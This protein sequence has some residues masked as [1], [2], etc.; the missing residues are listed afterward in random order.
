MTYDNY[1]AGGSPAYSNTMARPQA[2]APA[3]P[4]MSMAEWQ[5]Y[6]ASLTPQQLQEL[7]AQAINWGK[8]DG[9]DSGGGSWVKRGKRKSGESGNDPTGG[10]AISWGTSDGSGSGN[11]IGK[12]F[13]MFGGG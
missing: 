4:Q 8:L 3:T 12:L 10:G 2:Q 1:L 6:L 13:N 5:A 11:P 7:Q 9:G